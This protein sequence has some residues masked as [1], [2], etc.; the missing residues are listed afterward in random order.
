MDD[1][2]IVY[3]YNEKTKIDVLYLIGQTEFY[4]KTYLMF[5]ENNFFIF[6]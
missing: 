6:F 1:G 3:D 5:L 2:H 4:L